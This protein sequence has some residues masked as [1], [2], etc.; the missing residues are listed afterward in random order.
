[1]FQCCRLSG[2]SSHQLLWTVSQP[3]RSEGCGCVPIKLYLQKQAF[4]VSAQNWCSAADNSSAGKCHSVRDSLC[5]EH[6]GEVNVHRRPEA[7]G[8]QLSQGRVC[9]SLAVYVNLIFFLCLFS[10]GEIS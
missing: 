4:N 6:R 5:E 10:D 3:V 9:V 8:E 2:I 7:S 1:M